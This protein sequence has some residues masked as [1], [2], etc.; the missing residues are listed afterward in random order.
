MRN[1]DEIVY[2]RSSKRHRATRRV[3]EL[4]CVESLKGGFVF[5]RVIM[6]DVSDPSNILDRLAPPWPPRPKCYLIYLYKELSEKPYPQAVTFVKDVHS[7][8][9]TNQT[10]WTHGFFQP[11]RV[12]KKSDYEEFSEHVLYVE[13]P[14]TLRTYDNYF[15]DPRGN[16][17]K[18]LSSS[19]PSMY[20]AGYGFVDNWIGEVIRNAQ[21]T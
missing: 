14:T 11:I 7:Y 13:N 1:D 18:K 6:D 2:M 12:D 16:R 20:M 17:T 15:C 8:H 19:A 4:F 5:G 9:V 21:N 3:G 10:G